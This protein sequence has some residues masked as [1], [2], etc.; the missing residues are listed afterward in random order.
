MP[1][2]INISGVINEIQ[3]DRIIVHMFND[4]SIKNIIANYGDV[5]FV[6]FLGKS[7][8]KIKYGN[9]GAKCKKR[10][11]EPM[12]EIKDFKDKNCI[13]T[14]RIRKNSIKGG[15]S[16]SILLEDIKVEET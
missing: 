15:T 14:A 13:L 12:Y 9:Y 7:S 2:I 8:I 4:R 6:P 16:I 5:D 11:R 10:A 3:Q 1:H